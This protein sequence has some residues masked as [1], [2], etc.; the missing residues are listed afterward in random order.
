MLTKRWVLI[1]LTDRRTELRWLRRATVVAAVA[2]KHVGGAGSCKFPTKFWQ[3]FANFWQ[4]RLWW[5]KF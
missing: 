1:L 4:R 3:S 5:P 2:L